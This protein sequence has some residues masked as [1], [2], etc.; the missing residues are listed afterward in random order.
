METKKILYIF[1][2]IFFFLAL[3]Y[4]YKDN[5]FNQRFIDE[6]ENF[7][8][9]RYIL[10]GEKLYDD[11]QTSHQPLAYILSAAVQEISQPKDVYF[12]IR[13]E[14]LAVL[15]WSLVWSII[16][17]SLV[18]AP[19]LIFI[20]TFE[21][22]KNF[23]F[24]N[25]F[26]PEALSVYPLI[27]L[28]YLTL[29]QGKNLILFGFCTALCFFLLQPLWPMLLFLVLIYIFKFKIK[30]KQ[31]LLLTLGSSPVLLIVLFFISH[32]GYL[33][34]LYLNIVYTIPS[35][36]QT[37]YNEP[38]V[39]TAAKSFI[40][41]ILVVTYNKLSSTS[42]ILK[43]FSILFF[44]NLFYLI[45]KRDYF[46]SLIILISLGL[47]NLHFVNPGSE[48]FAAGILPWYGSF[49]FL[50][51]V[52]S[53][54]RHNKKIDIFNISVILLI[55]LVSFKTGGKKMIEKRDAQKDYTVN[56]STLADR[57]ELIKTIKNE[58]DTLFASPD[59]WLIYWAA[60]AKHLPKLF[61]YYPWMVGIPSMH[62]SIFYSFEETP[63]AFLYCTNCKGLDLEKYLM[64]YLEI[65]QNNQSTNL[66]VLK[67]SQV[68]PKMD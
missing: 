12:L 65:K 33:Y 45:H 66:Y 44:L 21:L 54:D 14:R 7:A 16:L 67:S 48:S 58:N 62:K 25:L 57:G 42:I 8:I 17:V 61:G 31:I 46:K 49:I 51:L 20:F 28:L 41:P 13:N 32:S 53:I 11:I 24:G 68:K 55:I 29:K 15:I 40:S 37:Y 34:S 39:L 9:G 22:T 19:A 23:I 18:G 50:S 60:D 6:E 52:I 3:S 56:F 30:Q 26:L 10:R 43:L 1:V 64:K 5:I 47:A 59:H 36:H 38:W 4:F 27:C 63:P 35:Y 2:S